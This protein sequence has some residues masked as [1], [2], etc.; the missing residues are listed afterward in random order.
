MEKIC[1]EQNGE[2]LRKI[3]RRR[4]AENKAEKICEEYNG[5]DLRRIYRRRSAE[6]IT[7]IMA[8]SMTEG[9]DLRRA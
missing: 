8:K 2:D 5:E 3:R 6:S 9:E 1:G 4:F 7:K